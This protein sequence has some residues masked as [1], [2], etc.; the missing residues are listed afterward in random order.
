MKEGNYKTLDIT[1]D[2]SFLEVLKYQDLDEANC[3]AELI[4]NSLDNFKD[5]NLKR[6]QI[7][8]ELEKKRLVI[9]D[10]GTGM[11]WEQLENSLKAGYSTKNK[12]N[13]L[14]LY[15]VGFNIATIKLGDKTTII[16][17][18][19]KADKWIKTTLDINELKKGNSFKTPSSLIDFQSD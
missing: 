2:P 7:N 11:N 6:C 9:T 19:R 10:N 13:N 14:G 3:V 8:I 16:T 17:K 1:P 15:G 12:I 4:D 18:T 5:S